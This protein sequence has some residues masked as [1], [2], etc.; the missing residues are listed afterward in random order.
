MNGIL[1][2]E[3]VSLRKINIYSNINTSTCNIVPNSKFNSKNKIISIFRK[4]Q[5]NSRKNQKRVWIFV[6]FFNENS[7][8]S[9]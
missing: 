1:L 8:K 6:E 7:E 9:N 4:T 5:I 2:N 3:N